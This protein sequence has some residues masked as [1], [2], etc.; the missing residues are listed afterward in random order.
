LEIFSIE[1]INRNQI[2]TRTLIINEPYTIRLKY[3][4][5]EPRKKYRVSINFR[6]MDGTVI[7]II[8]TA[9]DGGEY[10]QGEK[11]LIYTLTASLQN[12]LMSGQYNFDVWVKAYPNEFIDAI[13]PTG[14]FV[15]NLHTEEQEQRVRA[16]ININASW[17]KEVLSPTY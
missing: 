7:A 4:V 9:N 8:S 6:T 5:H 13:D 14:F 3:R 10:I 2:P 17:T 11:D 15:E 12:I 1:I 16:I